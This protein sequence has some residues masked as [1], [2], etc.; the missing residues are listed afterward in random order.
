M[1]FKIVLPLFLSIWVSLSADVK[2]TSGEIRFD[3]NDD[4]AEEMRLNSTGLGIGTTSPTSTLD[5]KGSFGMNLQ[6]VSGNTTL[7]S[8]SLILVDSTSDNVFLT[9]PTAS[10]VT[11]RQ[12]WIKKRSGNNQVWITASE[13]IDGLDGHLELTEEIR[14]QPYVHMVSDG[15]AWFVINST[16]NVQNVIAADNLIGWWKLDES[17]GAT[18]A[19]DSSVK[20]MHGTISNIS[21]DNVGVD[22]I[23]DEAI[24]FDG[25]NDGI[26]L[27]TY[28]DFGTEVGSISLFFKVTDYPISEGHLFYGSPD[29]SGDGF[30]GEDELHLTSED[31]RVSFFITG[32]GGNVNLTLNNS[33]NVHDGLWHHA[34]VVWD[35]NSTATLYLDN[36]AVDSD[37]H[38]ANSFF[39]SQNVRIGR[40]T[41]NHRY[42]NGFI[43]D[44]RVYNRALT[45]EEVEV[46]YNYLP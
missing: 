6:L 28:D 20:K 8:N 39:L 23:F 11:G 42:F 29:A 27:P 37:T 10:S 17:S 30:S 38:N 34:A 33:A 35:I 46:I 21:S 45:A 24:W 1:N 40:P 7:S 32:D 12:Y 43:D 31:D 26:I 44:V 13:T 14:F 41:N 3:V 36:V 9:L 25:S 19:I 5:L 2:S 22:G 18:V 15:S 16:P 4:N